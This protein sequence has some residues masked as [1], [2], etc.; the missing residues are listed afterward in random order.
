MKKRGVATLL[1]VCL[2]ALLLSAPTAAEDKL[3]FISI[4]DTLPP[5]L[6]NTVAVYGGVTYVPYWLFT[7]Y[8]LGIY[9]SY[10][11]SAST[12]Y[13]YTY[14]RQLFF[15]LSDGKTF[16]END[17][18]YST[19]AIMRGGTVYLPLNF[20]CN[21]FGGFTYSN[22]AGNE[23]GSILRITTGSEVLGNDEFL[24][25]AKNA[26]RTHYTAYNRH[27]DSGSAQTP[28]PSPA[29][30][31][32]SEQT[33]EGDSVRLGL[34][35][36]PSASLL[37]RLERLGMRACFF[38]TAAQVR[39]APDLVRRIACEGHGLGVCCP[40]GTAAEFAETSLL[41]TEAARVRTILTLRPE[42]AAAP[43]GAAA[44]RWELGTAA[45]TVRPTDIYAVTAALDSGSGD[46]ALLL[47]CGEDSE[48]SLGALLFYLSDR[49]FTVTAPRETD[50]I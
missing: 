38:L 3:S 45:E 46:T 28:D 6:I 25:A 20:M 47:P 21:Y 49:G 15:G 11:S 36:L 44:F 40:E 9:Y 8:G 42:E 37:E 26:M 18:Q 23:Y 29:Q 31:G 33:H 7:N 50:G 1:C 41:L 24:R 17:C 35:G 2:L 39:D 34:C 12:A 22:I 48:A 4:N 13:L 19:Q 14:D 5:E 32:Q 10:L 27:G 43:E 30:P 16:D